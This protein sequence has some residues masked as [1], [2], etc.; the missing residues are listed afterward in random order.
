MAKI[1]PGK[2]MHLWNCDETSFNGDKGGAK[3]ITRKGAKSPL[4][5]TGNN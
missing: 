1:G 5:L 2:I 3:E 4:V